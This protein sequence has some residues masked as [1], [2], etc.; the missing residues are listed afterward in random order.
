MRSVHIRN[1]FN[2]WRQQSRQLLA[3]GIAPH[4]IV[5]LDA[6]DAID[7]F[8][9]LDA[10]HTPSMSAARFTIPRE[11]P[12]LL[13]QAARYRD[14]DRWALLYRVLWRVARGDRSA[15]LAGDLDGAELQRRVRQVRREA[16]HM[17]A[18]LRFKERPQQHAAPRFVAWHEPAHDVLDL[19]TDHFTARLGRASWL[20]ATPDMAALSEGGHVAFHSPCPPELEQL[21]RQTVDAEDSLWQAYYRSTFNPARVNA[22]LTRQHMPARFWKNLPEGALIARLATEAR[23]ARPRESQVLDAAAQPG[24]TVRV[25]ADRAQ[26]VR[27][28]ET[29]LEACRGC[30]LWRHATCAVAGEGPRPARLML[31]GEQ[32]GDQEDL[33]GKPFIGPAGQ[34]LD[35]QLDIAGLEREALFMTNAVKHFKWQA[36]S[37]F[38]V[39]R[40]HRSPDP[41][42]IAACRPWLTQELDEVRPEV[43]VTL[44]RTALASLLGVNDPRQ[45]RLGDFTEGA[46]RHENRWVL[47]APH[48]AAILR[49]RGPMRDQLF[50]ALRRALAEARS[51]G[52]GDGPQR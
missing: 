45:L 2:D 52:E 22:E 31:I 7:L 35:G 34:L 17:E 13:E 44:G 49:A 18:F 36:G 16:H 14:P 20:I 5:W 4:L 24:Q 19:V 6:R 50:E 46:F 12:A 40:R 26:P 43:V 32:P 27:P 41:V 30:S 25:C 28:Q 48:P 23:L 33:A 37:G 51:L 21:A 3:E 15:M 11:L 1:G 42:E 29:R 39:V 10:Q 8:A 47:A 9:E 38:P